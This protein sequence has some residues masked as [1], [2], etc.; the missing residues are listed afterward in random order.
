[1]LPLLEVRA[2]TGGKDTLT[3]FVREGCAPELIHIMKWPRTDQL[4]LEEN[5]GLIYEKRHLASYRKNAF[6]WHGKFR[7]GLGDPSLSTAPATS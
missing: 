1:M 4:V 3:A 7:F 6:F 5:E 2:L